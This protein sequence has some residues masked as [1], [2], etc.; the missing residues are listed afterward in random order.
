L[1]LKLKKQLK[2]PIFIVPGSQPGCSKLVSSTF[3]QTSE[4]SNFLFSFFQN[5]NKVVQI[6]CYLR[7]YKFQQK[8]FAATTVI[9]NAPNLQYN[10]KQDFIEELE[11]QGINRNAAIANYVYKSSAQSA[12]RDLLIRLLSI[13]CW[14]S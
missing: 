2:V 14:H 4:V 1:K 12:T 3:D 7:L 6:I 8:I 10:L 9:L 11:N 5:L 13:V